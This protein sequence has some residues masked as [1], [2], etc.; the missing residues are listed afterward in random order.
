MALD[1]GTVRIGVALSD[2]SGRIAM[3]LTTVAARPATPALHQIRALA[4]EHGVEAIVVGL[5]IELDG[6]A[7]ATVRTTRR[8]AEQVRRITGLVV[9][10]WDERLT[11]VAA[12]RALIDADVRRQKRRGLVDQVAAT[13]ILQGWLDNRRR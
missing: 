10:E 5:P 2:P 12:E 9:H 4:I 11:S 3:P 1:I 13:M 6:T 7:G 8:V